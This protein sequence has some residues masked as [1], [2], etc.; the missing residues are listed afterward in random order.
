MSIINIMGQT[1]SRDKQFADLYSSYI[2]QQQDLI[3]QQQQQINN[4]YQMNLESQ[5]QMPSNM[6]FQS[7]MNHQQQQQQQQQ[8]PQ[9]PSN[10]IKLDPY[11]IL[12]L[13]K[14]YDEK[15]LKKV[16]SPRDD[17]RPPGSFL[18]PSGPLWK[19]NRTIASA[20][21]ESSRF[22]TSLGVFN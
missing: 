14:N 5:Q 21:N 22:V 12:K 6:F 16:K 10:K 9:L 13:P 3:Y 2:Q 19:H 7:D 4:L 1:P 18:R 20:H 8:L 17:S 15:T 11:K